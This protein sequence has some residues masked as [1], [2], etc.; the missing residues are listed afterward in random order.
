MQEQRGL[1]RFG[2]QEL[3]RLN[4]PSFRCSTYMRMKTFIWSCP[5]VVSRRRNLDRY[6]QRFRSVTVVISRGNWTVRISCEM[7]S[8]SNISRAELG[9]RGYSE[10]D[11]FVV[12]IF[13]NK[14]FSCSY[15]AS[16]SSA[17]T[18]SRFPAVLPNLCLHADERVRWWPCCMQLA[19]KLRRLF[20]EQNVWQLS[21]N[22]S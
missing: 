8:I 22:Q 13:R 2:S 7:Q 10:W 9:W 17:T 18:R 19:I 6:S 20:V 16:Q 21:G 14:S 15:L 4:H 3:D 5:S 1:Q 11:I 12:G